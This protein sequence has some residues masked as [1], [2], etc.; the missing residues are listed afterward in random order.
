M[1]IVKLGYV[2]CSWTQF[3]TLSAIIA[4]SLG[5]AYIPC[6]VILKEA[7]SWRQ[8][9]DNGLEGESKSGTIGHRSNLSVLTRTVVKYFYNPLGN[10]WGYATSLFMIFWG[11]TW[12]DNICRLNAHSTAGEFLGPFVLFHDSYLFIYLFDPCRLFS[13]AHLTPESGR[14]DSLPMMLLEPWLCMTMMKTEQYPT[15]YSSTSAL[16]WN[17]QLHK[18]HACAPCWTEMTQGYI[19]FM[20]KMISCKNKHKHILVGF[21]CS[22]YKMR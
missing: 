15:L 9:E 5:R 21:K 19:V 14:W 2:I 6:W 10:L 1:R 17:S 3:G 18:V 16:F 8:E 20:V 13:S 22:L 11:L 4:I 7:R 12:S